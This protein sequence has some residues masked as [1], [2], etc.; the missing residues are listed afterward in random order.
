MIDKDTGLKRQPRK[1]LTA[2][3]VRQIAKPGKYGD[4]HGLF[5]LVRPNGTKYWVQ[6]IVIRGKRCDLG[7]GPVDLVSLAEA[8]EVALEHRKIVRNGGD[9]RQAKQAVK[10]VMTFAEAARAVYD[11][12]RP[13]WRNAKH[14]AQFMATLETYAFPHIGK[15][16]VTEI[17]TAE[18]MAVLSPIWTEKP[19]TARRVCQR[20][21]TVMKWCIAQG[22][23]TDNPAENI[24]KA[25]PHQGEQKV[26]RKALP[27]QDVAACLSVV[28]HSGAGVVTRLAFEFLVLTAC[29][30][31]EVRM[32]TWQEINLDPEKRANRANRANRAVWEIPA[33][34]M[35]AK[36]LH[37]VPL[38]DRAVEILRQVRELSDGSD[39]V[40]PGIRAG[41]PLSDMTLSKLIKELGFDADIHGFRTSFRM[42]AQEQTNFPREVAEAALAHTI[43]DKAEA[44]YARSDLFE[45]RREMMQ[46]WEG[47]VLAN[48]DSMIGIKSRS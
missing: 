11:L 37:R 44:A 18:V 23:R 15:H 24:S 13:T 40:F 4:G 3:F 17:S 9:P 47:Y 8:R 30:S 26:H 42:W 32:A 7:L 16:R 25:L 27:Y 14:A 10:E 45:K 43:R 12:H 20:V 21:G 1:A 48:Q 6:R 19:E 33:S 2:A 38:C 31:G 41:K 46:A 35:K 34:R 36:K 5:L 39:L 29:R 22:W 28:Q